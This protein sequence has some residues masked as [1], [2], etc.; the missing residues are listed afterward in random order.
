MQE[1]RARPAH[2]PADPPI[3]RRLRLL[4]YAAPVAAGLLLWYGLD[5]RGTPPEL[6]RSALW[7]WVIAAVLALRLGRGGGGRRSPLPPR[8]PVVAPPLWGAG[9]VAALALALGW[10]DLLGTLLPAAALWLALAVLE[11]VWRDRL[12]PLR[13][14]LLST[15]EAPPPPPHPRLTYQPVA[16]HEPDVL[17]GLGGLV[18]GHRQPVPAEHARLLEHA[19]VTG[20]PLYSRELLA[21]VLTGRVSLDLVERDW[22][23]AERF[24]SGYMPVK[25]AL[26]VAV[27][28]LLPVLLPL[29]G[30]VALVVLASG[31]RPVLFWQERIGLGGRPFRLVKFRTMTR[32]SERGGAAFARQGDARIIPG[33]AF[34]RKFRLDE[35]PQFYNVLRGEM[36]IIGP[37]P[38]QFAFAADLEESIPLYATR[39]WVR[40]GITGWA[41]V[42]QGYTDSVDQL[43]E[44]LQYDF[45]Y[46]KHL[47]PQLDLLIVWKTILTVLTGFGA[48]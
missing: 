42:T 11:L 17:R 5:T 6:G 9:I 23:D 22:L 36:S 7:L 39:H 19:R 15:P 29:M 20:V 46:V 38:E 33:G 44:K 35:L 1:V 25:R 30:A 14:G 8:W 34:L 16:P 21:E 31:G 12:P 24:Q 45:Y 2:L 48:R 47:S 43:H 26:D 3:R 4:R 40:P 10:T 28:L 37:R 18:V 32:D 41:Q 13:L 27:T